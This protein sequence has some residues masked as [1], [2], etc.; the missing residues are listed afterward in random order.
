MIQHL[1]D[2]TRHRNLFS[3]I[4]LLR[5]TFIGEKVICYPKFRTRLTV[6]ES[7]CFVFLLEEQEDICVI[8]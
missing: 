1:L 3:S 5:V 6:V 2:W 7:V 8:A 4:T